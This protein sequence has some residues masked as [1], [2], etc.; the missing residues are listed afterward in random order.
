MGWLSW[1]RNLFRTVPEQKLLPTLVHIHDLPNWLDVRKNELVERYKLVSD[2]LAYTNKLKSKRWELECSVDEWQKN[3]PLGRRDELNNFFVNTRKILDLITF[4][5]DLN[6]DKISRFDE[7]FEQALTSL[8][9]QIEKSSFAEDFEFMDVPEENHEERKFSAESKS[10]EDNPENNGENSKGNNEGNNKGNSEENRINPLLKELLEFRSLLR[11]FEGKSAAAG[12]KTVH[13]LQKKGGEF[14]QR[15]DALSKL[16]KK[17]QVIE[18]RLQQAETIK[19]EKEAEFQ[20]LKNDSRYKDIG[21]LQEQLDHVRKE[22]DTVE[23]EVLSFFSKLKPLLQEYIKLQDHQLVR[24][25]IDDPGA[26]FLLDENVSI[27]HVLEH[28]KA[29]VQQGL[30]VIDPLQANEYFA[31]LDKA[32][33]GYLEEMYRRQ[34]AA[35]Q[36]LEG[37]PSSPIMLKNR[38]FMMKVEEARYRVQ[39]FEKQLR[40]MEQ[41]K[42]KTQEQIEE[43]TETQQRELDVF[44][45]TAKMAF[46]KEIQVRF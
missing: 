46:G 25:Y 34:M 30:I 42:I 26:A 39:H 17:L 18:D 1:L 5:D 41:R 2:I 27:L 37:S 28:L 43:I 23:T 36:E 4:S 21:S 45:Q 8:I 19:G 13:T 22:E 31:L 40:E 14:Q 33:K 11:V 6:I 20:G 29:A 32:R 12:M 7:K 35:H 38:D 24:S 10:K 44:I 15:S 9:R 16:K 3:I